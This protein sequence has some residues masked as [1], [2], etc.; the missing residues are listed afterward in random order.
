MKKRIGSILMAVCMMMTL[1]PLTAMA[2]STDSCSGEPCDHEAAIDAIHY[3]TLAEALSAATGGQTVTLLKDIDNSVDAEDYGGKVS[4]TLKASTT[5]DGDGHTISGH[6]GVYIPAEGATV[7]NVKFMNI[8][9][10][11]VVDEATC[12]KK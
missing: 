2:G 5:L 6:I 4:Y 12:E 1:L 3:D 9:N 8:H 11:V 10:N 7:K